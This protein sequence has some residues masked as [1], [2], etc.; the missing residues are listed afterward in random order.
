MQIRSL[1]FYWNFIWKTSSLWYPG[2]LTL[3]TTSFCTLP[4]IFVSFDNN[5]SVKSSNRSF[6]RPA[7][8]SYPGFIS[9]LSWK[10][11][12]HSLATKFRS[13]LFQK[14]LSWLAPCSLRLVLCKEGN[15]ALMSKEPTCDIIT[16]V[17]AWTLNTEVNAGLWRIGTICSKLSPISIEPVN[18]QTPLL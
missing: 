8:S 18:F 4:A 7:S 13:L 1:I 14:P 10:F 9:F 17:L 3:F 5:I 15:I 12:N 2:L 6:Q 11:F 16:S